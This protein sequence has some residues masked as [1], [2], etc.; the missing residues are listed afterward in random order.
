VTLLLLQMPNTDNT[1]SH[2]HNR[3][4]KAKQQTHVLEGGTYNL[5]LNMD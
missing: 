4:S 1:T 3:K 5:S 2:F